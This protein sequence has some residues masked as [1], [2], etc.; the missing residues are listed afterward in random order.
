MFD[1]LVAVFFFLLK[2]CGLQ[3][4]KA[5]AQIAVEVYTAMTEALAAK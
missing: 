4:E 1:E 5:K 2:N 3:V